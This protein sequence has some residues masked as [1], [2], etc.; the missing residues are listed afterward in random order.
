[1]RVGT[2]K[3]DKFG[4][5]LFLSIVA[6]AVA[7]FLLFVYGYPR[8]FP[9]L[10]AAHVSHYEA[11]VAA[12]VA[13]GNLGDALKM[14]RRAA[15]VRRFDPMAYTVYGRTL[16]ASGDEENALKQLDAA[17]GLEEVLSPA[18][19]LEATRKPF[20]FA[21]ARL[22]LG[23]HALDQGDP[24]AAVAQFELARAYADLTGPG[25]ASFQPDLFR[26]YAQ[27]RLWARALKFGEPPDADLD[28][29]DGSALLQLARV[30]EGARNWPLA[31]RVA[32]RLLARNEAAVKA[33]YLSG[34]A[35]LAREQYAEAAARL[36]RAVAGGHPSAAYFLGNALEKLGKSAEAL[37]AYPRVASGDV[38]RPFALARALA[39]LAQLPEAERATAAAAKQGMTDELDREIA[40]LRLLKAPA[41]HE[42]YRRMKPVAVAVSQA[43][44]DSGGR[45][46]VLIL[47]EAE[48]AVAAVPS[49]LAL[50]VAGDGD[51]SLLLRKGNGVL[52]L[53]WVE[54]RVNWVA[55]DRLQTGAGAVP[56]WVDSAR[57]WFGLRSGYATQLQKDGAG[58]S[59][60]N[61]VKP[62]WLFSVPV[63]ARDGVGYLVA[64]RV[65]DPWGK[66][67]LTW[68]AMNKAELVLSEGEVLARE[69]ED[70]WTWNG[71]YVRSQ[72]DW[73]AVRLQLSVMP[74]AGA[75]A[76]DDVML[77]EIREPGETFPEPPNAP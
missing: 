46:P 6:V 67:S 42:P 23:K 43:H 38:H 56:G 68:Q 19:E 29:L 18:G 28:R 69:G 36:E 1:M 2:G 47:W 5:G 24:H 70:G 26:A 25:Y 10:E 8:L 52:Q 41:A 7:L 20:Y 48:N 13:E 40:A 27:L 58:N 76:F 30:A 54:N 64:S 66:A 74:R 11:N 65:A 72:L 4:V 35:A 12:A 9:R 31:E 16:L 32:G 61:V 44:F 55:V 37:Q 63:H 50:S 73:D 39:L 75:V 71:A 57:D 49:E 14:A 59:C 60:L 51:E 77:V 3:R 34:R 22:T 62:T 53:Q 21:P 33:H 17:V 15:R 45:F